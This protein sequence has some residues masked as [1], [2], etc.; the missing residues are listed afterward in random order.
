MNISDYKELHDLFN[1]AEEKIKT[2]E[3]LN[4]DGIEI[5]AVNE[6]WYAGQHCLMSLTSEDKDTIE[7][8]IHE[9]KDHCKR[10]IYDAM[11]MGIVILLEKIRIFQVD[12]RYVIVTDVLPD[13][14][15][16]LKTIREIQSF[17]SKTNR[18]I[19][20]EDDYQK[21]QDSYS[22]VFEISENLELSREELNK[23][24]RRYKLLVIYSLITIA[25]TLAGVIISC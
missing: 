21:I 12:Y 20:T 16:K 2:V 23:K 22:Q 10:A 11:E 1:I 9:A 25:I 5:P 18:L 19:I 24:N 6:L 8:N 14:V 4:I 13:Y 7:R 3:H 15:T 17:I